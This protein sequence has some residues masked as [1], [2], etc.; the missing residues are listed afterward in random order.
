MPPW[1]RATAWKRSTSAGEGACRPTIEPLP[2]VACFPF[3]GMQT[4]IRGM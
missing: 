1:A 2:T 3:S 4:Q